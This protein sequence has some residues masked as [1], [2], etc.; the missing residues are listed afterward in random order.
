MKLEMIKIKNCLAAVLA[1]GLCANTSCE[2]SEQGSSSRPPEP[3]TYSLNGTKWITSSIREG[4]DPRTF[5]RTEYRVSGTERLLLRFEDL[6]KKV[7]EISLAEGRR[8]FVDV[9]LQN[10]ENP[11]AAL[12]TLEVCPITKTWMR[13]ATWYNAYPMPGGNWSRDGGD[14]DASGCV[15]GELKTQNAVNTIRY[16]VTQW[17]IDYVKARSLNYGLI[18][19]SNGGEIGVRGDADGTYSP[20]ISWLYQP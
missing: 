3:Q 15:R 7:A 19:I 6:T 10:G 11:Q 4:S 1:L 14:F 20:R 12:A 8:V 2:I 16:D 5:G 18:L 13:L 9:S 17:V